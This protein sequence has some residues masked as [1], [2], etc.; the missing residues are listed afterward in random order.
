[1]SLDPGVP[2]VILASAVWDTPAP[3]NAHQIARRF[4]ARGH[5]VLFVESTGLRAP[6]QPR[7]DAPQVVRRRERGGS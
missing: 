2:L 1:M 6:A 3:V 4:A 5:P 7:R